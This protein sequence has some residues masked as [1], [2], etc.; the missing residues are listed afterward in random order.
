MHQTGK[1]K[2]GGG[3]LSGRARTDLARV[4]VYSLHVMQKRTQDLVRHYKTGEP[5]PERQVTAL[6]DSMLELWHDA[7]EHTP[8]GVPLS[9][10]AATKLE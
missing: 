3:W 6:H 5:I 2:A 10:E 4:T 7:K 1:R 8:E 9:Y